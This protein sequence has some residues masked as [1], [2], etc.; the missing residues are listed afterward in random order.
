MDSASLIRKTPTFPRSQPHS[1]IVSGINLILNF[2]SQIQ[3]HARLY[4]PR[5]HIRLLILKK[6][7]RLLSCQI[8]RKSEALATVM[9]TNI[10][11]GEMWA[12]DWTSLFTIDMSTLTKTPHRKGREK[13]EDEKAVKTQQREK[14][15]IAFHFNP[16]ELPNVR[17]R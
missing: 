14:I 17:Q 10:Q 3:T 1:I 9:V 16:E 13:T 5:T 12:S 4:K 6:H 7:A 8:L 2:A 15:I 11:K